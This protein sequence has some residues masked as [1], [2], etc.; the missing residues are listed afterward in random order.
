MEQEESDYG[1]YVSVPYSPDYRNGYDDYHVERSILWR[2]TTKQDKWRGLGNQYV[3]SDVTAQDMA[4]T[5]LKGLNQELRSRGLEQE[6]NQVEKAP[7][8]VK[9][10]RINK[11]TSAK[12]AKNQTNML[13]LFGEEDDVS[14]INTNQ[15]ERVLQGNSQR[16]HQGSRA[17]S[18]PRL[19]TGGTRRNSGIQSNEIPQPDGTQQRSAEREG[20]SLPGDADVL[21]TEQEK[22]LEDSPALVPFE[23]DRNDVEAFNKSK[24]YA[25]NIEAIR[26][27]LTL[28]TENRK[29][30][31][32]EKKILSRYVGFGGLKEVLLDPDSDNWNKSDNQ[33]KDQVREVIELA[34]R[35]DAATGTKDT[36]NKMD[37]FS[38]HITHQQR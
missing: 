29:A 10:K 31:P 21:N 33:Y 26:T 15:D 2:V 23:A 27:V 36:F 38:T 19:H 12:V 37:Q 34:N 35:F 25:D 17:G 3:N 24:K 18:G 8:T 13:S 16:L 22:S 20:G 9:N 11:K 7:E 30:T 1:V 6:I 28:I 5:L 14:P 4:E 32:D